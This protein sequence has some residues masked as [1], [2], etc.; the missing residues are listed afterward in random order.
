MQSKLL[1]IIVAILTFFYWIVNTNTK[2]EDT[3]IN[4]DTVLTDNPI[5]ISPPQIIPPI[6][7]K[8]PQ[9]SMNSTLTKNKFHNDYRDTI[10]S[11]SNITTGNPHRYIDSAV[12]P[13][14][15]HKFDVMKKV[16]FVMDKFNKDNPWRPRRQFVSGWDTMRYTLGLP[17]S[18][19]D[20]DLG[21]TPLSFVDVLSYKGYKYANVNIYKI[22]AVFVKQYAK[23]QIVVHITMVNDSIIADINVIGYLSDDHK[24]RVQPRRFDGIL[25]SEHL[26]DQNDIE[27]IMLDKY[28]ERNNGLVLAHN[29][30]DENGRVYP[31]S[32][33]SLYDFENIRDT[34]HI[35]NDINGDKEREIYT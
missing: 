32:L 23:D 19:Y 35:F 3:A 26:L 8:P 10:K 21:D 17:P 7:T 25:N 2:I 30:V 6:I 24:K 22:V 9:I 12:T 31:D 20:K 5:N 15:I 34:H 13:Q 18:L 11:I 14:L 29:D 1:A 27:N 4:N 28:N 33:P 16:L